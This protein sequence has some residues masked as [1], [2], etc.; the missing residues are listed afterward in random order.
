MS[1][2]TRTATL[3]L[4]SAIALALASQAGAA[5]A[6]GSR[7]LPKVEVTTTKLPESVDLAPSMVSIVTG[8]DLRARGAIDLR[9]ALSLVAGVDIAPGGDNGP[10]GSVP[11]LWGLKEFDAFLLVVDGVPYGGAFNPALV[12]LDLN[13]IERIEVLRGAAPVMYGATSFV[14]V[15]HVIHH[16]AGATPSRVSFG[17]GSHG[18]ARV[19]AQGNLPDAGTFAQSISADAETR[20]FSQDRSQVDRAHLLYRAAADLDLG[21]VHVDLDA[22]RVD[23]EPY[24]PH[25]REGNIL[26]TRIP[27]DANHNPADARQ[28]QSRL[29][30]NAGLEKAIAPGDWVTTVSLAHTDGDNIRGFL[31]EG[32][33]LDGSPNADGYDQRVRTT[34]AYFDTFVSTRPTETLRLTYGLDWLYGRG[35]QSSDNFE[36]AVSADGSHVPSSRDLTIDESTAV[37][38]RRSFYGGYVQADWRPTERLDLVAGLRLN[39]THET[40]DAR[41]IDRHEH[42]ET[43]RSDERNKTRPSGVVGAS[44]ALWVDGADRLTLFADYRNTYK[45]AAFDFGP[46]AEGGILAPETAHSN[47][48]GLK[49]RLFDG[50][51]EW[52]ASYFHM[53]FANLVIREN[54]DG[55]PALA[56]AGTER[57]KGGEV[58]ASWQWTDDLRV[59]G[60]WAYHDARFVNYGRLRPNG[61]IQQ[62]GG[63][64]L[65]L[66]PEHLGALGLVYAPATGF[67]GSVVWNHVGERFLNKGN[68][69]IAE[70]YDTVDLGVGYRFGDWQL[71]IDEY[72]ATDRRDPVAESEIGDAQFYRLPGRSYMLSASL[73]WD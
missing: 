17:A 71:R 43:S 20:G 67:N 56:N 5:N 23:Q 39:H 55:L 58:E 44:Y 32:F 38:D 27:L 61:S 14:G 26:S 73:D 9:T 16:A 24:S 53:N 36:Y 33:A 6:A 47:E 52:E 12:T 40:R 60:S 46:E 2:K 37:T 4:A 28:D 11:G 22:T 19:A 18:T 62:L 34:D 30:L 15:I 10:A 65:E 41:E 66:S 54:I 21:R 29:Q 51:L 57:F 64:R 35:R 63:N 3:T 8:E 1:T 70:S 25:P 49:G 7:T 45:P 69:S 31:R 72:N 68:S 50:R 59:A 42:E 48:A 13:A